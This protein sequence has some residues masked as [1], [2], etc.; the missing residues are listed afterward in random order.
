FGIGDMQLRAK[1]LALTSDYANIALGSNL[2][3]PSGDEDKALGAGDT[4]LDES[5]YVSRSFFDSTFEP[6][7][8]IGVEVNLADAR[9]SR[10]LYAGGLTCQVWTSTA[11]R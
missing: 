10:L 4:R 9:K 6:H 3:L 5:A 1:W 2:K 11:H 8:N 7:A